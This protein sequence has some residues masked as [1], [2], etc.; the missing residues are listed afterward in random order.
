MLLP[1]LLIAALNAAPIENPVK[2]LSST[3]SGLKMPSGAGG[4]SLKAKVSE[5]RDALVL[6]GTIIDLSPNS[7][8]EL[9]VMLYFPGSGTTSRGYAYRFRPEGM[10]AASDEAAAPAFAQK[11]V[12]AKIKTEPQGWSF[13]AVISP[14]ALPRFQASGP[15]LLTVC[16]EYKDAPAGTGQ[17]NRVTCPTG[18]M[19]LGP[20]RLPDELRA[21]LQLKAPASIEAIEAREQGWAGYSRLHAVTWVQ[22]D[23]ASLNLATLSAM[24]AGANA[25]DPAS[26]ALPLP[27]ELK[28]FGQKP[29]LT[30]LTG[31]NPY[32]KE[33]CDP[34]AELRMAFFLVNKNTAHEVLDW[35]AANCELGRAMRFDFGEGDEGSLAIG[36]TSG[37]TQHF[38]WSNDHFE[39]SELGLKE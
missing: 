23:A 11:N 8:D 7:S 34:K 30:V 31:K 3:W 4:L 39:R 17:I 28:L 13:E 12:R 37:V 2:P 26:A 6:A 16:A 32:L 25:V 22:T 24:V 21:Q 38:I 1:V 20:L 27:K 33:G 15:L 5:K 29:L 14:R 9:E 19:V 10:R 36:Y 35:P 18:E